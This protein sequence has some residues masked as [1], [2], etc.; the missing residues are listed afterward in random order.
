MTNCPN[1]VNQRDS[2]E[3]IF[4]TYLKC[5]LSMVPFIPK[6][7][8]AL[9]K[10]HTCS[11]PAVQLCWGGQHRVDLTDFGKMSQ[12]SPNS[13]VQIL[14]GASVVLPSSCPRVCR[15][16]GMDTA[17]SRGHR[18]LQQVTQGLTMTSVW[19]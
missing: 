5:L 13:L 1:M 11:V 15:L 8:K 9:H 14:R 12:M 4:N 17:L 10:L 2:K 6:D 7:P 16:G 3:L 18:D 19:S